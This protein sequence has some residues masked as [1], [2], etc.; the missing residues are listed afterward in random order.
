MVV[1]LAPAVADSLIGGP[2]NVKFLERLWM[3]LLATAYAVGTVTVFDAFAA[4][5]RV[6]EP[7]AV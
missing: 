6:A 1:I 7:D 4:R 3:F 2:A 5:R